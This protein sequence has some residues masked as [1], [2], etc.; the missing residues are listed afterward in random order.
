MIH[1]LIHERKKNK[2]NENYYY[3]LYRF[4][5]IP[6]GRNVFPELSEEIA[7]GIVTG[8]HEHLTGS[9]GRHSDTHFFARRPYDLGKMTCRTGVN[10]RY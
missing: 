5:F 2:N 1:P 7:C 3:I 6:D 10:K 8:Y 9:T 4:I